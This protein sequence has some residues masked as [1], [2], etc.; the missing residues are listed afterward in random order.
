M[1]PAQ[2]QNRTD[3]SAHNL[4]QHVHPA[5]SRILQA[6]T[7]YP[8]TTNVKESD[9]MTVIHSIFPESCPEPDRIQKYNPFDKRERYELTK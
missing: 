4:E 6:D 3:A 2:S 7:I 8:R 5:G 1:S 9:A